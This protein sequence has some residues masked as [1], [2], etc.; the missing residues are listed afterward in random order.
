VTGAI[1]SVPHAGEAWH[2]WTVRRRRRGPCSDA[3]RLWD[4]QGGSGDLALAVGTALAGAALA[5]GIVLYRSRLGSPSYRFERAE[6]GLRGLGSA[7]AM[8]DFMPG[9][10][11][12]GDGPSWGSFAGSPGGGNGGL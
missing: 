7:G 5:G 4:E 1:R 8:L 10:P 6:S 3:D 2:R 11:G 9:H 12:R